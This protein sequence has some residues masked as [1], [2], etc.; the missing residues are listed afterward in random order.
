MPAITTLV[1]LLLVCGRA[2]AAAPSGVFAVCSALALSAL[3]SGSAVPA[4]PFKSCSPLE[5]ALGVPRNGTVAPI[6]ALPPRSCPAVASSLAL[7][8][9][10]GG[11]ERRHA[12]PRRSPG[13]EILAS[14][15][16]PTSTPGLFDSSF[17]PSLPS[18]VPWSLAELLGWLPALPMARGGS[19]LR[20][21]LALLAMRGAATA[22]TTCGVG[23]Y[24]GTPMGMGYLACGSTC[25]VCPVV[26][27]SNPY[28]PSYFSYCPGDDKAYD[29]P[30][31]REP[32][33]PPF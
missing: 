27:Y 3:C 19:T 28:P 16:E 20:V 18:A 24:M 14:L 1:A 7:P 23:S 9:S 10:A 26:L 2:C 8:L 33:R 30:S 29:C 21:A 12:T 25:C 17:A 32:S 11:G 31:V 15:V 22:A 5:A 6:A 13:H 4:A